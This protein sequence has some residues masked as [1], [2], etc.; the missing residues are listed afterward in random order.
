MSIPEIRPIPVKEC[1]GPVRLIRG[2]S[3]LYSAW[4]I[5][6]VPTPY[7]TKYMS[8]VMRSN[9]ARQSRACRDVI[10]I[11]LFECKKFIIFWT[12]CDFISVITVNTTIMTEVTTSN[13]CGKQWER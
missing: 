13:E 6:Y 4:F 3:K 9:K 1:T 12:H 5:T 11:H 10:Q 8:K 2:N 7:K